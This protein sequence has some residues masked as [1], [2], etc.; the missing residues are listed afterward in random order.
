M[1]DPQ[2]QSYR[3]SMYRSESVNTDLL[4][5]EENLFSYGV[6]IESGAT[7]EPVTFPEGFGRFVT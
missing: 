5:L 4:N 1:A 2:I 6:Y 3:R 7:K